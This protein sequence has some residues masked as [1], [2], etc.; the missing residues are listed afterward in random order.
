MF[1][2]LLQKLKIVPISNIPLLRVPLTLEGISA[3][4]REKCE[5][6]RIMASRLRLIETLRHLSI[7]I[8]SYYRSFRRGN[9]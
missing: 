8:V 7:K 2:D 9:D 1:R 3:V 4:I 6:L 5:N